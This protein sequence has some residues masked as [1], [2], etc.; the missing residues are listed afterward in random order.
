MKFLNG[1]PFSV[2]TLLLYNGHR[3]A[4]ATTEGEGS[5]RTGVQIR[6]AEGE[7]VTLIFPDEE[8][9]ALFARDLIQSTEAK[10]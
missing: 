6:G 2:R 9:V 4:L 3:L 8:S 7:I 1:E 5:I 10:Q